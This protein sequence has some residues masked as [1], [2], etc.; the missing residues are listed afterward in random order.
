MK[1]QLT[2]LTQETTYSIWDAAII[3]LREGLEIILIL[4]AL[5]AFLK[6]S[7]NK[8]KR[9][10]IWGSVAIMYFSIK[11]PV[12][13]LF[14]GITVLIYYLHLNLHGKVFMHYRLLESSQHILFQDCPML[15]GCKSYMGNNVGTACNTCPN[16]HSND[17]H[18]SDS[19]T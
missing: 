7:D 5:L 17:C 9:S 3:L 14:L 2:A 16:C 4:A 6:Q 1:S 19:I 18:E 12:R 11:I 15:A 10:W 13:T 8:D